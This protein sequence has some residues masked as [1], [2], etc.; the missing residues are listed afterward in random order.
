MRLQAPGFRFCTVLLVLGTIASVALTATHA[1]A[2]DYQLVWSDEFDGAGVDPANW[3]FQIGDGC[4][5]LCGWGNNELQYYR[6]ENA[7]VSGGV[8]EISAREEAFMGYDYTSA[9]LRTRNL[10]DRRY[11]RIETRAK[12]PIGQGLWPAFWMLPTDEIYGTWAASGEIDIMEYLGHRPDEVSGALHYGGP[13]PENVFS[14]SG[15]TLSPGTFHDDFHE[16][17]IEWTPREIRWF[18]DQTEYACQSHWYSTAGSYPAPFDQDFHL[19]LNM[20]VGG[21]LPGD[22]DVT[23]I[24]PQELVVDYVRVSQRPEFP[25]CETL[26]GGLDHSDPFGHGW[27]SFNG[28][29]GGGGIGPETVDLPP[30]GC[31]GSLGTAWGSGGTPGYVGGFGRNFPTDLTQKTHFT[32]W[33][34][35]D[36]GQ[37]YTLEINLQDDDDGD[38]AVPGTP[39]GADDEFQYNCVVSPAGPCAVSGGGWQ[40]V[41]I[42]L[43]DFFD[44]GSFHFGGNGV[45]DPVPVSAG[46]N[47]QLVWVVFAI[48]SNSGADVNFRTDTWLFTR[49]TASI[50]GRVWDDVDGDGIQ[51]G[52][53]VGLNGVAV[54]LL[55]SN[56]TTVDLQMTAGNGD[57][58]FGGLPFDEYTVS[59]QSGTTPVGSSP[60]I[61]P[62]GLGSPGRSTSLLGCSESETAYDFGYGV[63]P[64][65]TP[66]RRSVTKNVGDPSMLD[67]AYDTVGCNASD[68]SVLFGSLTDF[69]AVTTA[70]CSIGNSGFATTAPPAGSSWFLVVGRE[71]HR[72]SSAGQA[73]AG[74][75]TMTGVGAACPALQRQDPSATCP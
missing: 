10:G 12:M 42:A 38:D 17:A 39:D 44:D 62:D 74:E 75:R 25:E 32:F 22:P 34:N 11:G 3:E 72:Y 24:F 13:W 23:T 36:A 21:N 7:T 6:S 47:G 51:D 9:R 35:P 56:S 43:I 26:F 59:V 45:L 16:F 46:G 15:F 19:L 8:L 60:T 55:D 70:D 14:S 33:I 68:H 29:V 57:Y 28:D 66:A 67:L 37:D 5:S 30:S 18:V 20:A 61:D 27:T 73:T 2:R 1:G 69:A 50:T 52:G 49:E 4:P 48:V 64:V 53:E 58:H 63:A 40:R 31:R 65:P 41:S 54:D 71:G